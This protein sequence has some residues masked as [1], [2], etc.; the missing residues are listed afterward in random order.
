MFPCTAC[1]G[2]T[3]RLQHKV[4]SGRCLK[5]ISAGA[6]TCSGHWNHVHQQLA[7]MSSYATAASPLIALKV[8]PCHFPKQEIQTLLHLKSCY[9]GAQEQFSSRFPQDWFTYQQVGA[10]RLSQRRATFSSSGLTIS[11]T[12]FLSS[13]NLPALL[14]S[15]SSATKRPSAYF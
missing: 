11:L 12:P 8:R 10:A 1:I 14:R 5:K 3:P 15:L 6:Y 2:A 7:K 13:V 4:C 9:S